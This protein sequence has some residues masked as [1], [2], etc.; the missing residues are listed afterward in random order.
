MDRKYWEPEIETAPIGKLRE[1]Q[2]EKLKSTVKRAYEK[3]AI[4]R[5]K[6]DQVGI[7]PEDIKV[8][9]DIRKLPLTSSLEE[10]A[11]IPPEDR[12]AV[13]WAEVVRIECTSGTTGPPR[14]IFWTNGDLEGW[15]K[16]FARYAVLY[17]IREGDVFQMTFAAFMTVPGFEAVGAKVIPGDWATSLPDNQVRLLQSAGTVALWS[18]PAQFSQLMVRAET[19]GVDLKKTK[20]RIVILA[21]ESWSEAYRNKMERELG[22]TFREIYGLMETADFAGECSA[23]KGLH[24]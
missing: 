24:I 22:I 3:T 1:I 23:R 4:Y 11:P 2:L 18:T 10:L 5:K 14:L 9:D 8:L 6:F 17:G 13:P 7:K 15:R 16:I 20:L 21:G 19:L 12:L